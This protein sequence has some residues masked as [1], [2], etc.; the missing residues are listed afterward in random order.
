LAA[1]EPHD[2]A[3]AFAGQADDLDDL[4][5][6]SRMRVV[7]GIHRDGLRH[8]QVAI[9]PGRLQHDPDARFQLGPLMARIQA[10]HGDLAG[11]APAVTL[12]NLYDRGLSGPIRSEERE[13]LPGFDA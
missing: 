11:V 4:V 9:H 7:A 6:R 8:R 1:R 5:H 3:V 13:Y 2:P 12:Q 10:E